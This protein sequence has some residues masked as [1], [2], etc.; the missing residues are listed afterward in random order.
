MKS[1]IEELGNRVKGSNRLPPGQSTLYFNETLSKEIAQYLDLISIVDGEGFGNEIIAGWSLMSIKDSAEIYELYRSMDDVDAG[2][3]I[4]GSLVPVFS[5]Q[6]KSVIC[7]I[8]GGKFQG[9]VMAIDLEM[10]RAKVVAA[11]FEGF[12]RAV[13]E[14]GK[15]SVAR[16]T[17]E[18]CDEVIGLPI[19]LQFEWKK[20]EHISDYYIALSIEM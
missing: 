18:T 15:I 20:H 9:S 7:Q 6:T 4:T 11:S 16:W 17:K 10:A 2:F 19:S 13:Y 8:C 1:Q 3:G 12:W 5:T 14:V